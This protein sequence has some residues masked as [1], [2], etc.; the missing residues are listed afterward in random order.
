M[1]SSAFFIEAAAN[2]VRLLSCASAGERADPHRIARLNKSPARRCIMA[3]R[4]VFAACCARKSGVG[5]GGM[6]QAEAPFRQSGGL[7]IRPDIA[8]RAYSI[9]KAEQRLRATGCYCLGSGAANTLR[10]AAG[11]CA[12]VIGGFG[13]GGFFG[14]FGWS[15]ESLNQ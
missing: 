7:T 12:R 5:D 1:S 8:A 6:R 3:L 4:Y 14:G 10:Q 2:T 13:F 11:I 9:V 15:T